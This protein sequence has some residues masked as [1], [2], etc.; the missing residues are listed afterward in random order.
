MTGEGITPGMESS[1]LAAPVLLAALEQGDGSAA[2]LAGYERAFRAYF[3]P[4][5]L[6]LDFCAEMLRNRHLARP[7]LKALARGCQVAQPRRRLRA[8]HPGATSAA[9]TSARSTSSGRSGCARSRTCCSRGRASCRRAN[10]ANAGTYARRPAGVAVG[11]RRSLLSDPRWHLRWTLDMQRPVD[12]AARRRA[13]PH[14]ARSAP[15]WT[16]A[17]SMTRV[18]LSHGTLG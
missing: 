2:R 9:S 1:L 6:F 8:H 12:P 16:A 18:D 10:G 11:A 5:M 4:S 13:P 17:A 15:R 7:W 14:E 3:D